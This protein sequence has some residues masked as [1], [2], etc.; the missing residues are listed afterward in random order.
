[1]PPKRSYFNL[2]SPNQ[3]RA[4]C[5]LV[6]LK[7]W[8]ESEAQAVQDSDVRQAICYLASNLN[9]FVRFPERAVLLW[10]GCDRV[11]LEGKKQ[12]IHKY[13]AFIKDAARRLA[14]NLDTRPNGPA[15][16]SFRFAGGERPMR[17]GSMNAWSIHHLYSGKFPHVGKADTLHGQKDGRHF[18]QSAGLVAVHPLADALSDELPAFSWLLRAHAFQKY[19]YDPDCVFINERVDEF[20]FAQG[21]PM[22]IFYKG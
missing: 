9:S 21:R 7:P 2:D 10:H 12:K 8:F 22:E 11:K 1:M 14:I 20:G 6:E 5:S 18:T 15:I 16:A 13:P 19:G 3:I 4:E 17:F